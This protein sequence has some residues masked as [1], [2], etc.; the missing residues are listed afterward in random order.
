MTIPGLL[1]FVLLFYFQSI[2]EGSGV[3]SQTVDYPKGLMS[4]GNH[5][6]ISIIVSLPAES[7]DVLSESHNNN[8]NDVHLSC[9]HQ[10]PDCSHD[11]Y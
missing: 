7:C 10:R 4:C 8:N 9:T 1:I 3:R 2:T 11:T 5:L 6:F